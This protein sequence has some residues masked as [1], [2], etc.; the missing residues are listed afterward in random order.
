[1]ADTGGGLL[2]EAHD[3]ADLAA[4]LAELLCDSE[5]AD[6]LGKAGRQAIADRY[7]AEAMA[8]QT[9]ELYARLTD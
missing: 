1:M 4:K 8:R 9:L 5:K 3:V 6:R 2:H 7:H